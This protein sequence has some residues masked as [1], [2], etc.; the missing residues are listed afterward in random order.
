MIQDSGSYCI[1]C[2]GLTE[3]TGCGQQKSHM[4]LQTKCIQKHVLCW[5]RKCMTVKDGWPLFGL[6]GCTGNETLTDCKWNRDF[7]VSLSELENCLWQFD[8]T[9]NL[10]TL[11]TAI[12][13]IYMGETTPCSTLTHRQ[14]RSGL[15]AC[16]NTICLYGN[17]YMHNLF[18]MSCRYV[19]CKL[20]PWQWAIS[21]TFARKV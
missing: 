10:L 11:I 2:S 6:L 15:T 8:D 19:P 13:L 4:L 16:W 20:L 18:H 5:L 14:E 12:T 3:N 1:P 9:E 17:E 7:K 21:R